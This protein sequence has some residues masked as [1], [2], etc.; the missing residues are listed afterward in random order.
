[1]TRSGKDLFD[2]VYNNYSPKNNSIVILKDEKKIEG[3]K[4]D[5][6]RKKRQIYYIKIQDKET[7][8]KLKFESDEIKEM[9]LYPDGLEKFGKMTRHMLGNGKE[10]K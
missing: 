2:K 10:P 5:V 3:L 6:D 7:G 4:K 8:R 1:M 9:H